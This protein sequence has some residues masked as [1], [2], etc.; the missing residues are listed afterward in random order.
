[1]SRQTINTGQSANDGTGD[2]LR[3][4]GEKI[5]ANFA[6]LYSLTQIGS[7]SSLEEITNLINAGIA[8]G[9]SNL[10]VDSSVQN[11]P[12]IIA[13][14]GQQNQHSTTIIN[15]DSDV[16]AIGNTVNNLDLSG[17]DTNA[18]AL[19]SLA[20][21]IDLDSDKISDLAN[22][23][24]GLDSDL[25]AVVDSD[26]IDAAITLAINALASDIASQADADSAARSIIIGDLNALDS[27]V[28]AIQTDLGGVDLQSL[29]A[30][31]AAL[32]LAN[33]A[34]DSDLSALAASMDSDFIAQ[35]TLLANLNSLLTLSDSDLQS[36]QTQVSQLD[37]D[38]QGNVLANTLS[39][40]GLQVQI[41]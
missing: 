20:S 5:N 29:I 40:S 7:G 35:A 15:L 25:L 32:Q 37:S 34:A 38:F 14:Q 9:L 4:A 2:N 22:V 1:M 13:L 6:E 19:V 26:D 33:V 36:L 41:T 21:R 31:I 17:I 16:N 8:S 28:T 27:D 3:S 11:S 30:S 18:L 10:D 39:I 23:V 24:A 12:I